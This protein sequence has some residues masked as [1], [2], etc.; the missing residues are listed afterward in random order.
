MVLSDY[1][2]LLAAMPALTFFTMIDGRGGGGNTLV[3]QIGD[4][5]HIAEKFPRLTNVVVSNLSDLPYLYG[6]APICC[7]LSG[8]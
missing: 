6:H 8:V 2:A 4:L 7:T 1:V 3:A 5:I